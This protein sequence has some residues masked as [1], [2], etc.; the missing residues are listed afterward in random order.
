MELLLLVT[1][2]NEIQSSEF[3]IVIN[4]CSETKLRCLIRRN[5]FNL[6]FIETCNILFIIIAI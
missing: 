2:Q 1:G 6:N 5:D 4:V 3:L